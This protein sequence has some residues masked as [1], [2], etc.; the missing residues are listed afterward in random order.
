MSQ[1]EG[2]P[3][4][5]GEE[6]EEEE[7]PSFGRMIPSPSVKGNKHLPFTKAG[8]NKNKKENT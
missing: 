3:G 2:N 4:C 8:K 7:E 5:M 6:E 1:A